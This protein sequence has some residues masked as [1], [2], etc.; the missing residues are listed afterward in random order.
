MSEFDEQAA[1]DFLR[2]KSEDSFDESAARAFLN[3]E[4]E[5]ESEPPVPKHT[6]SVESLIQWGAGFNDN[7]LNTLDIP[8]QAFNWAAEKLGVDYRVPSTRDLGEELRIGYSREEEPDTGS[9]RSGK[10]T[11]MG[12]EFLTP[13]LMATKPAKL[14]VIPGAERIA[15]TLAKS[16][17][18]NPGVARGAAETI[19]KPFR[20]GPVTAF[21]GEIAGNVASGYGSY[22]GEQKYGALGE[23]IGGLGLGIAGSVV[24]SMPLAHR[25]A[26]KVTEKIF[27]YTKP[28]ARQRARNILVQ[29]S[30]GEDIVPT[31]QKNRAKVLG[32]SKITPARLTGDPDLMALE[33][34]LVEEDPELARQ[35]RELDLRNNV[36]ARRALLGMQGDESIQEAQRALTGRYTR[37]TTRL[38][39]LLDSKIGKAQEAIQG[40]TPKMKRDT[41][42][43]MIRDGI[44]KALSAAR[45]D[46]D[47][48]W[49]VC[50]S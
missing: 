11:S 27:P 30:E 48:L 25:L 40:L 44:D 47:T 13:F 8:N 37:L 23:Q 24:G 49:R 22:Y 14:A 38:N 46:E 26:N 12:L 36:V 28:G 6:S 32:S 3:K 39:G 29:S 1:R 17:S 21:S 20:V 18:N 31:I 33:R 7:L 34:V 4:P 42:N 5:K 2:G 45:T 16:S 15:G 19:A 10:F 43:T 9:Y 41:A 50:A 35:L